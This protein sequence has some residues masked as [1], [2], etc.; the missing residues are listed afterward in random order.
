MKQ[1]A[2]NK[3]TTAK[4]N[5]TRLDRYIASNRL[6]HVFFPSSSMAIVT[7]IAIDNYRSNIENKPIYCL[8]ATNNRDYFLTTLYLE[9]KDIYSIYRLGNNPDMPIVLSLKYNL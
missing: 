6:F 2:N 7:K 3:P 4:D 8:I 1:Y 5:Q 9:I